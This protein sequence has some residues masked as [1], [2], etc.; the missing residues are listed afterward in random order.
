[1]E[2]KKKLKIIQL[3]LLI[4]GIFLF[5][6]M[7]QSGNQNSK[8]KLVS[9]KKQIEVKKQLDTSSIDGDVFYNI[10]YSGFDLSGNRYILTAKEAYSETNEQNLVKMKSVEANF[11]FKDGKFLNIISKRGTYN[12]KTL[13]MFFY[14]NVSA[15]YDETLLS[16]QKAEYSNSENYLK[17]WDTVKVDDSRG[18]FIADELYFDIKK[19]TLDIASNNNNKINAN[20]NIK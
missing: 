16:A 5:I 8:V 2:R 3:T 20:I 14:K 15:N 17:I 6:F 10:E 9:Q 12:N 1:M 13:D 4:F 19:Q 7:Y 18:A 11:Y